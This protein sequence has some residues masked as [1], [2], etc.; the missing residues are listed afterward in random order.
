[1][2]CHKIE[3]IHLDELQEIANKLTES[4]ELTICKENGIRLWA[5]MIDF[6][7]I[8]FDNFGL[9]RLRNIT[10]EEDD[11]AI[12]KL[13]LG[14]LYPAILKHITPDTCKESSDNKSI[15]M[16]DVIFDFLMKNIYHECFDIKESVLSILTDSLDIISNITLKKIYNLILFYGDSIENSPWVIGFLDKFVLNLL[17]P[18]N[19][20]LK[21]E[22]QEKLLSLIYKSSSSFQNEVRANYLQVL[23][24]LK[25]HFTNI[26]DW[27][28][29]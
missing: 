17:K 7:H 16:N 5:I 14:K 20:E 18:G 23:A 8:K 28:T 6:G 4:S 21:Y 2:Q 15:S 27:P 9:E 13:L 11:Y 29:L 1:M 19:E 25:D 24:N 22:F 12:V 10:H 26:Y 3:K